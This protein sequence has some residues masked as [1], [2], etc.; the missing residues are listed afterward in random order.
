M[1]N[2]DEST[3]LSFEYQ[4][5]ID[6]VAFIRNIRL[7]YISAGQE[8]SDAYYSLHISNAAQVDKRLL[9]PLRISMPQLPKKTFLRHHLVITL[10][11][12]LIA[13]V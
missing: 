8:Y 2:E 10:S 12:L 7:W 5:Q 4:S 13:R 6:I 9:R 3:N 11:P 1:I